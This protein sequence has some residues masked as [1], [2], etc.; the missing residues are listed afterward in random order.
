MQEHRSIEKRII[1][2]LLVNAGVS[3]EQARKDALNC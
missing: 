3:Q 2:K 1:E